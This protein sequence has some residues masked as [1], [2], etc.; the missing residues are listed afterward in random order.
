MKDRQC[1]FLTFT[2]FLQYIIRF[3]WFPELSLLYISSITNV[4]VVVPLNQV[5]F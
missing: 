1:L 2:K 4:Y 5:M 3:S